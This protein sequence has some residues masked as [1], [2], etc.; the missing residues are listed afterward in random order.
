MGGIYT[1]KT[2][3]D[4]HLD[5]GVAAA[6]GGAEAE[7]GRALNAVELWADTVHWTRGRA[8]AGSACSARSAVRTGRAL[9]CT[10]RFAIL[11][12]RRPR[13][14]SS[15]G[16]AWTFGSAHWTTCAR[17]EA[18]ILVVHAVDAQYQLPAGRGDDRAR[19]PRG[20]CVITARAW[21][22]DR[23]GEHPS[24]VRRHPVLHRKPAQAVSGPGPQILPGHRATRRSTDR[25]LPG[26]RRR[27][28]GPGHAAH[29]QTTTA[30]APA[31]AAH[32]RRAR[33]AGA[34]RAP[35]RQRYEGR[36][37]LEASGGSDPA[38]THAPHCGAV[39]VIFP[40]RGEA[41]C[42]THAD[43]SCASARGGRAWDF[44]CTPPPRCFFSSCSNTGDPLPTCF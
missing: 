2:I 4:F 38:E 16:C 10:H 1:D 5:D 28:R 37:V 27:R 25:C 13:R 32:R 20:S 33:L 35:A 9:G 23:A 43:H 14:A 21:A 42:A 41:S 36:F 29:P 22:S 30:R 40:E 44:F 19:V 8:C 34:A 3:R 15:A 17:F 18:P 26:G 6:G 31:R 11:K 24:L 39:R 7:P 12:G